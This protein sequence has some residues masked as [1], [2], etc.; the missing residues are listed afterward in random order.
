MVLTGLSPDLNPIEKMWYKIKACLRKIATRSQDTL[1][2]AIAY[3]LDTVTTSN[4]KGW[5]QSCGYS[6]S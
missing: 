4:I 5:F 6:I 1:Y 3:A 2:K